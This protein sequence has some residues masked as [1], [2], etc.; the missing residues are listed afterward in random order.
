[1]PIVISFSELNLMEAYHKLTCG[2]DWN[3][4][5]FILSNISFFFASSFSLMNCSP[6][7]FNS[8]I[9]LLIL[10]SILLLF[11]LFSIL[12]SSLFITLFTSLFISLFL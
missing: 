2:M 4:S 7:L 3:S 6:K 10:F 12:I 8:D 11:F 9:F 1:M 5:D